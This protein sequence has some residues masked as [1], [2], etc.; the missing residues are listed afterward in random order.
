MKNYK[1]IC[2]SVSSTVVS[3][4][5]EHN[6]DKP[7]KIVTDSEASSKSFR[8]IA[9]SPNLHIRQYSDMVNPMVTVL[10]KHV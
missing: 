8:R 10:E 7:F 5:S 2:R 4:M 1:L 3:A 9:W 6:N